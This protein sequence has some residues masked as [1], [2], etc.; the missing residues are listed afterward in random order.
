MKKFKVVLDVIIALYGIAAIL[1]GY[2]AKDV[3][4]EV[5]GGIVFLSFKD[6]FINE[7]GNRRASSGDI[8]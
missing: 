2:Y 4:L 5:F 3:C 7:A 6:N 1:C 8:H